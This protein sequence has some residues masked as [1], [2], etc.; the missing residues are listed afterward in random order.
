ML[1]HLVEV[2]Q[3][4]QIDSLPLT[5]EDGDG[6]LH[7]EQLDLSELVPLVHPLHTLQPLLLLH[8]FGS[9]LGVEEAGVHYVLVD[10]GTDAVHLP[11]LARD[12]GVASQ[13]V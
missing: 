3:R 10:L 6:S 4:N 1:H 13:V 11:V 12:V 5:F 9:V 7:V 8:Y 2:N